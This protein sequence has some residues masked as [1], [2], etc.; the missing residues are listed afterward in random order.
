[1]DLQ[2]AYDSVVANS[3]LHRMIT[4]FGFDGN[5]IAWY[6]DFLKGRK[7]RVR[8]NKSVTEWY[9]SLE[10][11]PQ[12]QTDSTIL[13]DLMLNYIKLTNVDKIVQDLE[14]MENKNK[15]EKVNGNINDGKN[16]NDE[17]EIHSDSEEEKADILVENG[18]TKGMDINIRTSKKRKR[19]INQ[20]EW[21]ES[22]MDKNL[23]NDDNNTLNIQAF[24]VEIKNFADDCTLEMKPLLTKQQLTKKIKYGYRLN[25]QHGLNQFYNWTRYRRFVLADHKCST[26]TFSKKKQ[27]FHAYVY[28]LLSSR[29]A[30]LIRASI[31]LA[32]N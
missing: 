16:G 5:I 20:N 2:S 10:N 25:M 9:D 18:E 27:G 11:L 12:G 21:N 22:E 28:K 6:K 32:I 24:N 19:K 26:I 29:R 13:F 1:M 3:L 23:I 4:E 31:I 30:I 17:L 15:E 8:Y 7:M 14:K